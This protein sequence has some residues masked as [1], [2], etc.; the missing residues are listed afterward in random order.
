MPVRE[1]EPCQTMTDYACIGSN[2][3]SDFKE[4]SIEVE[5]L[6]AAL[7][8]VY[9][10][11]SQSDLYERITSSQ[12]RRL[13]SLTKNCKSSLRQLEK[14]IKKYES[15]GILKHRR[16]DVLR[17]AL[18]D[19]STLRSS[20][21]VHTNALNVFLSAVGSGRL[22]RI[23]SK[24][25]SIIHDIQSGDRDESALVI[26]NDAYPE[27][28]DV[29]WSLL[30]LELSDDG[31]EAA[32]IES[33][34]L[35]FESRLHHFIDDRKENHVPVSLGPTRGHSAGS[36]ISG[37]IHK[38]LGDKIRV[39]ASATGAVLCRGDYV[40]VPRAADWHYTE[41]GVALQCHTL[42][43]LHIGF[44][45]CS[46]LAIVPGSM[47]VNGHVELDES[48]DE[49]ML[50]QPVWS[51]DP[52]ESPH[53]ADDVSHYSDREKR[54]DVSGILPPLTSTKSPDGQWE[55]SGKS[56]NSIFQEGT[57]RR[58]SITLRPISRTGS[59]R[60]HISEYD[61]DGRL[62]KQKT[63]T[64]TFEPA[65]PT[66][67]AVRHNSAPTISGIFARNRIHS[68]SPPGSEV[69]TMQ[70]PQVPNPTSSAPGPSAS[71]YSL[72]IKRI[73]GGDF[74]RQQNGPSLPRN[75]ES[76]SKS[77]RLRKQPLES[78]AAEG[79][80]R[81]DCSYVDELQYTQKLL[82][83]RTRQLESM[84]TIFGR[85]GLRS[86]KQPLT[87]TGSGVA[88]LDNEIC[89]IDRR[90]TSYLKGEPILCSTRSTGWNMLRVGRV[91]VAIRRLTAGLG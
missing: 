44:L 28:A 17:F 1:E 90:V 23:E 35:W 57:K 86:V 40:V 24:L 78:K 6:H 89:N 39:V 22:G 5:S 54:R 50:Q 32:D 15:L 8:V 19:L 7:A 76:Q 72:E 33:H 56:S 68:S 62:V 26:A 2:A 67:S 38:Y 27:A 49:L 20:I 65:S 91:S 84:L 58:N 63:I 21:V 30:K 4:L 83:A 45:E 13:A 46:K 87:N 61:S 25:D 31:F 34:R 52:L 64:T 3:K 29:Q 60:S 80:M 77:T 42:A 55:R 51:S 10:E 74:D 73:P 79:S 9:A 59:V 41:T 47:I 82:K 75:I 85:L 14:H 18:E 88:A 36:S 70:N 53:V 81:H 16:R 71:Q 69:Q 37:Q 43:G 66:T 48:S 11:L 12:R